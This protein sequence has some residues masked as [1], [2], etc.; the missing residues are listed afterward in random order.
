MFRLEDIKLDKGSIGILGEYYVMCELIRNGFKPLRSINPSEVGWDIVLYG[1]DIKIQVKTVEWDSKVAT[2][3]SPT[4]NISN[5]NFDYL[6][7]VLINYS[8]EKYKTLIIPKN[9][10]RSKKC[11]EKNILV[12]SK[13]YILYKGK[14][15]SLSTLQKNKVIFEKYEDK[16]NLL[17][18]EK[19]K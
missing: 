9:K 3:T 5:W 15:I 17:R 16:W 1:L 7:I 8:E 14:S 10:F 6:V 4:I 18:N 12:D 19:R 11:N 2:S 13:G